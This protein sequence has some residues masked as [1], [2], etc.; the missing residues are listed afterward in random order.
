[1]LKNIPFWI[2][3]T[4]FLV[5]VFNQFNLETDSNTISYSEFVSQIE[6]FQVDKVTFEGNTVYGKSLK[7]V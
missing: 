2:I 1:M 4:L 6:Q 3:T 5:F 7:A